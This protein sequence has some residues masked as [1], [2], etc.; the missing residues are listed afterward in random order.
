[1]IL[2]YGKNR[3]QVFNISELLRKR[4]DGETLTAK[5]EQVFQEKGGFER[6]MERIGELAEKKAELTEKSSKVVDKFAKLLEYCK[7]YGKS[8]KA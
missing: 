1:M 8:F 2:R 5:E 3:K 7:K 4:R 6:A